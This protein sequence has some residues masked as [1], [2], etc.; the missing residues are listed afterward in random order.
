[1]VALLNRPPVLRPIPI[2]GRWQPAP[3]RQRLSQVEIN[4]NIDAPINI[5][6]GTLPVTLGAFIGSG[7]SFL[8]GGQVKSIRPVATIVGVGLAGFGIVNLFFGKSADAATQETEDAVTPPAGVPGEAS[9][10]IPPTNEDAFQVLE[11]RVIYPGE[12]QEVDLSPTAGGVPIQIRVTNPSSSSVTFDL[13]LEHTEDPHPFGEIWS[14]ETPMRV[15]MGPGQT[16]DIDT[17]LPLTQWR[18]WVDY[19]DVDVKIM[20]RRISGGPRERLATD[21]FFVVE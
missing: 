12:Q 11:G 3:M 8:V 13:I 9:D 6:L 10:P 19:I 21:R 16:R 20:K 2:A 5:G 17:E 15:T 18:A 1:M 4:P 7:V 14:T